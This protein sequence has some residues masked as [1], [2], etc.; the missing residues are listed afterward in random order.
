MRNH[1]RRIGR[2]LAAAG[3]TAVMAGSAQARPIFGNA[4][5]SA[6]HSSDLQSDAIDVTGTDPPGLLDPES[7]DGGGGHGPLQAFTV[8]P[9]GTVTLSGLTLS[10]VAPETNAAVRLRWEEN[11][12]T[13]SP[14]EP[15][16]VGGSAGWEPFNDAATGALYYYQY[17][18]TTRGPFSF[19]L[20]VD[21]ST[22]PGIYDLEFAV[23]GSAFNPVPSPI[24]Q[25]N[26]DEHFY[27]QVMAASF[28]QLTTTPA[29]G[30][31]ISFGN[32]LV[33]Q[34]GNAT[35][36]AANS[37]DAGSALAGT[38][39]AA[40]GEFSPSGPWD[41]GPLQQG[42]SD[43]RSYAYTPASRGPGSRSL[44]VTSDGGDATITLSGTGV[45]PVGSVDISGA[46]AG[47]VRIGST[48]TAG[49]MVNNF[50]DGNL[51]GLGAPSN[52]NG[53][54]AAGSGS[55]AGPGGGISLPDG[56]SQAFD[57]AFNPSG[58]ASDSASVS[59]DFSNGSADGTN[60]AETVDAQLFGTGVGPIFDSSLPPG[61]ALDFGN[62]R[63]GS[64]E[65]L[66]L[67]IGNV[68]GD[69]DGGN[70]ALTGLTLLS[71]TIGGADASLFA[72]PDFVANTVLHKGQSLDLSL[73]F[74]AMD[75]TG[76]KV[77]SLSILTD[78]GMPLGVAGETFTFDLAGSFS[79]LNVDGN[80]VTDALTDGVLIIR[81]LSGFRGQQLV[82]DALAPDATR[83]DPT[84][85]VEFLD[86]S[87]TTMLDVDANGSSDAQTD[88]VLALR[89]LFGFTGEKLVEDA[90]APDAVRTDPQE[91]LTFLDSYQIGGAAGTGS[92]MVA[93]DISLSDALEL[94][95]NPSGALRA[96]TP[97]P[98]S[99]ALLAGALALWVG[100]AWLRRRRAA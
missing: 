75:L 60:G 14:L 98:S 88:G 48:G 62:L 2:F 42:Q 57:F 7:W 59:I 12:N 82:Q 6:C 89:Y 69:A 23:A 86:L 73:T 63:P 84:E 50:G 25:W 40:G 28:P 9:G 55:F 41:F 10:G 8:A 90:L 66:S 1:T 93:G 30:G 31:S 27:V 94:A 92:P 33:G 4:N 29:D 54:V 26:S 43:S 49:L 77:A 15:H 96:T 81:Y 19:D 95:T 85:I 99:L 71:A 97:E 70:A 87:Q 91:I 21:E 16:L 68:S 51:S 17:S 56:G 39:P 78:Q 74:D 76:S 58:H 22:L 47:L 36:S 24:G 61:S 45:A 52:L 80:G 20:T 72:V 64:S 18:T 11:G 100:R 35:L 67:S 38:C 83:T 53:T 34:T 3:L 32:V 44:T 65:T 37:G 5:C 79:D 13:G 46:D